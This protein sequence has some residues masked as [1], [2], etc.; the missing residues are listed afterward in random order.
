VIERRTSLRLAR[1]RSLSFEALNHVIEN[2]HDLW[3]S[4]VAQKHLPITHSLGVMHFAPVSVRF[5][6]CG[7]NS[8]G[9]ANVTVLYLAELVG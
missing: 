2:A 4:A 5:P 9:T 6:Q 1:L 7:L 8:F 3:P